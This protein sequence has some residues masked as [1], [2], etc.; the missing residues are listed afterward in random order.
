MERT[1]DIDVFFLN[2]L[3]MS[4]LK[5]SC[6][7]LDS[8]KAAEIFATQLHLD[9][10][11]M[12]YVTSGS[13]K[14]SVNYRV[15]E[16]SI[17]SAASLFDSHLFKLQDVSDSFRCVCLFVPKLFMERNAPT[18]IVAIRTKYAVKMFRKP[19]M[20]LNEEEGLHLKRRFD[21]I[22][23]TLRN[24]SHHYYSMTVVNVL[25]A[26]FLDLSHFFEQH[27]KDDEGGVNASR[28]EL[29][30]KS[31]AELLTENFRKEH[32]VEYYAQR[33]NVSNHYL[34]FLVKK[35]TGQTPSDFIYEMLYC[36][37]RA[38]LLRADLSVQEVSSLLCF[39]DQSSF[40]K[41]FKRR[42]GESPFAYK[43]K[44]MLVGKK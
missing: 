34:S 23:R 21:D 13:A 33:L 9:S 27:E 16:L 8:S 24:K 40:G 2:D 37:A 5:V 19:V 11:V 18:E 14:L 29:M 7:H 44:N 4:N 42:A 6:V 15:F 43:A 32:K 3:F 28:Y 36:E 38:L 22:D 39:S 25:I 30:T 20:H 12:M 1:E 31:F 10:F 41:F 26:F 17:G 35:V